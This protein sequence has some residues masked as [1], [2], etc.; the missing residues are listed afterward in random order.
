MKNFS[1]D[2]LLQFADTTIEA[3]RKTLA[4]EVSG[5]AEEEIRRGIEEGLAHRD[6]LLPYR[7]VD[8]PP[9]SIQQWQY[10][11]WKGKLALLSEPLPE[12]PYY[13]NPAAVWVPRP[14]DV[15]ML[16]DDP[17]RA[18]PAPTGEL[19]ANASADRKNWDC[20]AL[21]MRSIML[22]NLREPYPFDLNQLGDISQ[23]VPILE[24][25]EDYRRACRSTS[26][27]MVSLA[28]LV[29]PL[30]LYL[31]AT[32]ANPELKRQ[33]IEEQLGGDFYQM[34]LRFRNTIFHVPDERTN[35]HKAAVALFENLQPGGNRELIL[36]L[37]EFYMSSL[38]DGLS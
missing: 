38:Y 19:L 9:G 25:V 8:Y 34:L 18:R 14:E 32:I 28:L 6:S 31:E 1:T 33:K 10:I 23:S 21:V 37:Q 30:R 13:V 7:E 4:D 29:E 20:M 3:M 15:I 36:G 11:R 16:T 12:R 24:S 35:Y 27:F 5:M 2:Q 22:L 17:E 26:P